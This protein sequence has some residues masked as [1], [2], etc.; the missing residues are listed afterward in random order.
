MD[1]GVILS[2]TKQGKT[3][4]QDTFDAQR[5]LPSRELEDIA[6]TL[7]GFE[8]NYEALKNHLMVALMP[9]H[10]DEWSRNHHKQIIPLCKVIQ[11]RYP[12]FLFSGDVG[13]GKT[14][15]AECAANRL[16]KDMGKEGF[17]LKLS[18]RVRGKGLHG[19]MSQLIQDAFE[20]LAIQ[21]GKKRLSFLLIDEADSIASLRST[22]QMH[23]EEKA[24]VNTLIQK[25]D[26]I[27]QVRG[28]A[29]VFLCT[30]RANVIDQAIVRRTAL[31]LEFARPNKEECLK[32]LTHDL[33]GIG[34]K[35]E[36]LSELAFL[37]SEGGHHGNNGYS[38]SDFRL[39]F[40]PEALARVFPDRALTFNVLKETVLAVKPSPRIA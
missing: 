21:A 16:T 22:E 34:L 18:T 26:E 17:L 31:H 30:N 10:V 13:T 36:E 24:A 14:V 25:I 32:L 29:V 19:E 9:D 6:E 33:E 11:Q 28:R 15:T 1:Y 27:R 38:Y 12:L 37:T 35:P 3:V 7:V 23:Q 20:N 4:V 5:E 40:L 39:R 2:R 8:R